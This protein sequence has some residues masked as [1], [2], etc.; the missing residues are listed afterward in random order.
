MTIKIKINMH[1]NFS[2]C[3]D[4]RTLEVTTEQLA[5]IEAAQI[6]GNIQREF[7]N[8]INFEWIIDEVELI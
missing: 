6:S 7:K 4:S 2:G 1:D 3:L 5:K 8:H